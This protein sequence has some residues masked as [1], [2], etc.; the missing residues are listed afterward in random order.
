MPRISEF[1][2]IVIW[3]YYDEHPPPHF[4]A[5]YGEHVVQVAIDSLDAIAGSLP[6]SA[7]RLVREWGQLH[8][9][10]LATM[11]DRAVAHQPLGKIEALP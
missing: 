8:R 11:W 3:L 1:Y 10:E 2:G 9:G 5:T 4:H 7:M 6:N